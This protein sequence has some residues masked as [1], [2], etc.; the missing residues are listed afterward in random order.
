MAQS[1]LVPIVIAASAGGEEAARKGY[2]ATLDTI[3]ALV[4]E[5][6][7]YYRDFQAKTMRIQTPEPLLNQAFEWAKFAIEKGW[8]CN[9]RV[10]CG[11]VG[12]FGPTGSPGPSRP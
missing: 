11:L 10:G 8:T 7:A 12:G 2:R 1:R 5:S 6:D 4:A 3:Q 9:D